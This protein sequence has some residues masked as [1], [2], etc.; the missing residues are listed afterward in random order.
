[1]PQYKT[2]S[3]L[4]VAACITLSGCAVQKITLDSPPTTKYTLKYSK[5]FIEDFTQDR[6]VSAND[7]VWVNGWVPLFD[8]TRGPSPNKTMYRYMQDAFLPGSE[9]NESLKVSI[10]DSSYLMEKGFADDMAF[11]SL[12]PVSVSAAGNARHP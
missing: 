1:M 7:V 12:L 10:L 5:V 6:K 2:P 11:V 3:L 4:A 8:G 9:I